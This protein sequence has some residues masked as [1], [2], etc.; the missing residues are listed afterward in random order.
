[1]VVN[2][3]GGKAPRSVKVAMHTAQW[4]Y[5]EKSADV[6]KGG[7]SY[8]QEVG[9]LAV[10]W[11]WGWQLDRWQGKTNVSKGGNAGSEGNL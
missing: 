2:N 8:R 7:N 9:T 6:S 5:G 11:D 10:T 3:T 4:L 1:M